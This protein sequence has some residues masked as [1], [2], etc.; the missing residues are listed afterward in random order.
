MSQLHHEDRFQ[1][2]IADYLADH[3]WL[4]SPNSSGYD[5]ERA[6]WPE[7]LLGWLEDSD[8]ENYRRIV[9]AE[10]G[11]A[12]EKGQ[13]KILDR[14]AKQLAVTEEQG[15]GTLN[16]LRNGVDVIGARR[17]Q[18]MQNPV[19][20]DLNPELT[21]RYRKNRLR[22]VREVIYSTR[23]SNRIDLVLFLNGIAVATIETKTTFSQSLEK[24]KDQYRKDRLPQG[25][26][27][28]TPFRGALVH[29][30]LTD[31]NIVMTTALRGS[32]T[33]FLPF[34]RG[35]RN[36]AGNAPVEGKHRTSYFWEEI[37]EPDTWLNILAKF[38]YVNREKRAD[39]LTGKIITRSQIRFPRY[40]QW[41]AVSRLVH[42]AAEEGPGHKYLIQHSAGSGKTDSIAWTAHRLADLQAADGQK[43]FDSVIVISDRQVLDR[44]L[45]EA[46][47]QLTNTSGKFQPITSGSEG[48][49][50][51]Q[52]MAAFAAR[53]PIIGLTLQT[54]PHALKKMREE[55]GILDGRRF[56]VI[57]D[58]AHTSQTGAAAN[59]L[60]DLLYLQQQATDVADMDEAELN[61][62]AL[63]AMAARVDEDRRISYFAFT[64]TPKAK[65]LEIFGRRRDPQSPPEPFDLYSMKQAIE[66]G[67]ILDVLKNYTSYETAARIARR[68]ETGGHQELDIRRSSRA[69][70]GKVELHPTNVSSKVHEI[71]E[72][73]IHVVQPEL[74][75]RAKAMVVTSSRAAAVRYHRH[76]Q[77]AVAERGL[78]LKS[79]VAFSGEVEDPDVPSIG[80]AQKHTVTEETENPDLKGRDLAQVF[81][82]QDHHVLIV[83]NKYQ[84]G[85]DEPLLVAMYV[86]KKLSGI[87]AVQTLSRLNRQAQGKDNTYILDFIPDNPQRVEAAF[88]EYYEDAVLVKESDPELVLELRMKLENKRIFL[89]SEVDHF[90]RIWRGAKSEKNAHGQINGVIDIAVERFAVYWQQ[91]V[92]IYI[93]QD[94]AAPLEELKEFR[95]TLGAYSK[96]YDF[97]SQILN[98]GDE[99]Y[100]KLSVY[101]EKLQRKLVSFTEEEADPDR[102]N[103]DDVVLTH[104]K[105]EKLREESLTAGGGGE[106]LRG[107]TEA[108]IS[109]G[110]D[111][112]RGTWEEVIETVNEYLG[113][114]DVDDE[115][116]LSYTESLL[117]R[118]VKDKKLQT[119][120]SN[121]PEADF[122]HSPT[123]NAVVED[124]IWGDDQD[125]AALAEAARKNPG[126]MVKLLLDMG[127]YEQLLE[128]HRAA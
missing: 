59:A 25:E 69:I 87:S 99:Y 16:V 86:D 125:H 47:N 34:D 90:W 19:S 121:N 118:A 100:E 80:G 63:A 122:K 76:F 72:H 51:K 70:I 105:L 71:I 7:D 109:R 30:G 26:P 13:R 101:A 116:K 15:G 56:A 85:F 50:T 44:Q 48:S 54:F 38:I 9:P 81:G 27:L 83:A 52:L 89:P 14:V 113:H 20:T 42:A 36:G 126:G 60:K 91:A 2:Q 73:F 41:R 62:E 32:E 65:T 104:F 114:L 58:E 67:F 111:A 98:F 37:L 64:A 106:G 79:L 23:H 61:Q 29:F 21:A 31:E 82:Q 117:A 3:G 57:A 123:L 92:D 128:E 96:A 53:V 43:V 78:A 108:G 35:H 102:I 119:Q 55:G 124:A 12:Q 112:Q 97:F 45:Q 84:T 115:H 103:L 107:M 39:P 11:E 4:A 28:L 95:K 49:K 10:P 94:D 40:H 93:Q 66:E 8:P 77:R 18:L 1:R 88:R 17:F 5:K 6:L 22:V 75:G 24:V 127:L 33:F 110:G 120:A 74:G 46:V 68:T